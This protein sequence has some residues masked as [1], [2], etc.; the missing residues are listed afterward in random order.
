M[1]ENTTLKEL[2]RGAKNCKHRMD[3]LT[4]AYYGMIFDERMKAV[5]A[6]QNR[7]SMLRN[8]MEGGDLDDKQ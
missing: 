6:D 3:R 5:S 2:E 4:G 8:T 7:T 1:N